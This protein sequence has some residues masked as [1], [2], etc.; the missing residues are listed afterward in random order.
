MKALDPASAAV[1]EPAWR[2]SG[3]RGSIAATTPTSSERSPAKLSGRPAGRWDRS[4]RRQRHLE[5][6][7]EEGT[8]T[9]SRDHSPI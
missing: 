9:V 5:I 4:G 8:P 7:A 1:P 3:L 2:T 6:A